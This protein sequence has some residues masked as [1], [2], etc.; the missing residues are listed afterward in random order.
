[1]TTTTVAAPSGTTGLRLPRG[2]LL[3]PS[4]FERRHRLLRWVLLAHA[5]VLA[6]LGLLRG[7]VPAHVL[8]EVAPLLALWALSWPREHARWARWQALAVTAG[9]S[10]ASIVL[11]HFTDG[12]IEAHFHFFIMLGFVALYQDWLPFAW[13]VGFTVLSH[14]AGSALV[15]GLI[16]NHE[17]AQENPWLWSGIHGAGVALLAVGLVV[18]WSYTEVEQ[19]RA[20]ALA[21]ELGDRELKQAQADL[22]ARRNQQQLLVDLAR[23]NQGLL[24]RQLGSIETLQSEELAPEKLEELYALDHMATRMRRNAE[25]LL[26]LS[27]AEAP[28]TWSAPMPLEEVLRAAAVEVEDYQ[29]VDVSV[30]AALLVDGR[31]A[32]DLSHLFAEL[33]ENAVSCSPPTKRVAVSALQTVTGDVLVSVRDE[34][35]GLTGAQEQEV[36]ELLDPPAGREVALGG[37]LGLTVVGRLARRHGLHVEVAAA[38]GG[39]TLAQVTVPASLVSVEEVEQTARAEQVERVVSAPAPAAPVQVPAARAVPAPVPAPVAAPVAVPAPTAGGRP[40]LPKRAEAAGFVPPAPV[41]LWADDDTDDD[42]G[43]R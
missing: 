7:Q 3:S 2:N 1:M 34:G 12:A 19:R 39:G 38:A 25:S 28:R 10:W 24:E 29:R 27:G 17:H 4:A 21:V 13:Y 42:T 41:D 37:R 18:F 31:T 43:A 23:R 8:L 15:P 40:A 35:I 9:F 33:V 36:R 26:V 22:V 14:G 32:S 6:A 30:P 11:V 20:T 16:Y 5:P